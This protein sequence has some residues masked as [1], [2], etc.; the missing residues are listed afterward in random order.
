MP[1]SRVLVLQLGSENLVLRTK[2]KVI[3]NAVVEIVEKQNNDENEAQ[4][5][6]PI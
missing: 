1:L 3:H 4:S 5:I 6:P 2:T